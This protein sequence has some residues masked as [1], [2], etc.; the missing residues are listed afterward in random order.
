MIQTDSIGTARA[1]YGPCGSL[2]GPLSHLR[3]VR[4]RFTLS[5]RPIKRHV[6]GVCLADIAVFQPDF[7]SYGPFPAHVCG[8]L[9]ISPAASRSGLFRGLA[10]T[11]GRSECN[12]K[13]SMFRSPRTGKRGLQF[14]TEWLGLPFAH[15]R[16]LTFGI[17]LCSFTA[18]SS[19]TR[20][21]VR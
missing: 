19:R 18:C 11:F 15:N 6:G 17:L 9:H 7:G 10:H 16:L 14:H 21:C 20:F 13:I 2:S 3:H 12:I 1:R 4:V 8:C 5:D